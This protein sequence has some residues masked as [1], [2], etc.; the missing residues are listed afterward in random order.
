MRALSALKHAAIDRK[1]IDFISAHGTATQANDVCE[2]KAIHLV[3]GDEARRPH[4]SS[5]KAQVGHAI[6]A[7][8]AIGAMSAILAVRDDVVPPNINCED[9]DPNCDL[10]IPHTMLKK[11]VRC[12][13]ANSFGFG[14]NNAALLFSK[15]LK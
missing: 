14:S 2:A 10:N 15:F 7:A 11:R 9:V 6:G 13:L 8:G 4:V 12:G 3:L 5:T 1:Q